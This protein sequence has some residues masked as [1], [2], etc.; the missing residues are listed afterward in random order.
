VKIKKLNSYCY[1]VI[2]NTRRELA[3]TFLRFQEHYESP[4]FKGKI[5]SLSEFKE[6]Y[7]KQHNGLF[8]YYSD[9]DGFNIPSTVLL[10]FWYGKFNKL[11]TK[12][13]LLINSLPNPLYN[14]FYII[15]TSEE[16]RDA[17]LDH[18]LV[19]SCYYIDTV[20]KHCV[21]D[22]IK[23]DIYKKRLKYIK[24][25]LKD[26][27]YHKDVWYDEINAYL[28]ADKIG[29]DCKLEDLQERLTAL[30]EQFSCYR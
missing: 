10:P 8:T 23:S 11:S 15:G 24:K 29:K 19:H 7:R 13:Q 9:W 14:R 25:Y 1:Q 2:F 27:G 18:E 30:Y 22:I 6:W 5:F 26:L 4:K 16:S 17:T 28:V 20:Y 3:Q 12:E 21:E